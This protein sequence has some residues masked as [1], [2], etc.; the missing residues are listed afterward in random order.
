MSLDVFAALPGF[1]AIVG[2]N[3]QRVF[4]LFFVGINRKN[5]P[6]ALV[7]LH[8]NA[9][10]RTNAEKRFAVLFHHRIEQRRRAPA[11]A[12]VVAVAQTQKRRWKHMQV[13]SGIKD[14]LRNGLSGVA[15]VVA[16]LRHRQRH[17]VLIQ[18]V[19]G[20]HAVASRLSALENRSKAVGKRRNVIAVVFAACLRKGNIRF[21]VHC[22]TAGAF[23]RVG[24]ADAGQKQVG[25][26]KHTAAFLLQ[27]CGINVGRA[28]VA[29]GAVGVIVQMVRH[30]V[31]PAAI[32]VR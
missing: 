3:R 2:K 28:L 13:G 20:I 27:Q 26:Q 4:G 32:A 1:A 30:T 19:F 31:L 12:S 16:L 15:V 5:Q 10:A 29:A 14:G 17:A 23:L 21:A 25:Q 22:H 6:F 7:R 9:A 24:V 18:A 8:G 11:F